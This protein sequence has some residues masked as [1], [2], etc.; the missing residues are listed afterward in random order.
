MS[1][2]PFRHIVKRGVEEFSAHYQATGQSTYVDRLQGE[3][4]LYEQ[5]GLGEVPPYE[6]IILFATIIIALL[7]MLSVC[8]HSRAPSMYR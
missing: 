7:V 6:G 1:H 5:S 3:A 4:Q 2:S 8:D